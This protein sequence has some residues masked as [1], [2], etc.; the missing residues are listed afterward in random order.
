VTA[1]YDERATATD[2]RDTSEGKS[3]GELVGQVADDLTTLLRQE[4]SLARAELRQEAMKAGR[5]AAMLAG[6]AVTALLMLIFL[7][8]AAVD[9]LAQNMD[10]YWA[11]LIVAVVWAIATAVLVAA[12]RSALRRIDPR[13][14]RTIDT[15]SKA[16]GA[17]KGHE[18]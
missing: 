15:L 7:S 12:G 13:P 4:M 11:A 14:E 18:A 3:L 2:A 17:L 1:G 6:A 9:A 16:P 5:G 10:R 8:D